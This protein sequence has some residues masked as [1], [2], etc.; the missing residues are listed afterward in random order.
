MNS[1]TKRLIIMEITTILYDH[2]ESFIDD[3]GVDKK[4]CKEVAQ[5]IADTIE[6]YV[7]QED[8]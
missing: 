6:Q 5:E 7:E 3:D 2:G 1:K 8:E 4:V